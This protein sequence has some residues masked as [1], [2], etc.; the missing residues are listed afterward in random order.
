MRLDMNN[1][2][3]AN[4]NHTI[5]N[6]LDY[7]GVPEVDSITANMVWKG[8]HVTTDCPVDSCCGEEYPQ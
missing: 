7:Q 4:D 1:W 3:Q 6:E 5:G 8:E 2:P